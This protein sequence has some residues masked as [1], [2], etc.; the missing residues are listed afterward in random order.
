MPGTNQEDRLK[1]WRRCKPGNMRR[2]QENLNSRG[3]PGKMLTN[4]A[5]KDSDMPSLSSHEF[6]SDLLTIASAVRK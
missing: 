4:N 1:C 2:L 5:H 3:K 6:K